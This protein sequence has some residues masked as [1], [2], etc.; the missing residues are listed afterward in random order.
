MRPFFCLCAVYNHDQ[1]WTENLCQMFLNQDYE[2]PSTLYLLDDRPEGM[3]L[4]NK[5]I[6]GGNKTIRVINH[7]GRFPTLME[8][9]QFGAQ[10]LP[11]MPSYVCVMDDDDLYLPSF[12]SSHAEV[13]A[14]S[15]W[16]YP[17][18]IWSTYGF[19]ARKEATGNRFWASSA[20][21]S[22]ALEAIGGYGDTAA[23]G[24]DQIFLNRMRAKHGAPGVPTKTEY[25]YMWELTSNN[26]TSGHMK[27]FEDTSWYNATPP[28][29]STGSLTPQLNS[30]A[31]SVLGEL[32]R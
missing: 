24:F 20:Y 5:V 2:H 22:E 16:S 18:E 29:G 10:H 23:A 8:K 32:G 21:R 7:Q 12:L 14:D 13:L 15:L 26:H 6:M 17:D 11:W 19:V 31:L 3:Q 28:M 1:H 9:Y 25:V 30:M 27:S 4:P